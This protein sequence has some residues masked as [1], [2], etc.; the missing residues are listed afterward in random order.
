MKEK[1]RK[2][3]S[4]LSLRPSLE[5][6]RNSENK[7]ETNNKLNKFSLFFAK[8]NFPPSSRTANI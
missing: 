5:K 2:P 6:N 7:Q 3:K 4:R 8:I 1:K